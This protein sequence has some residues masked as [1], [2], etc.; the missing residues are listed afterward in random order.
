MSFWGKIKTAD[1]AIASIA[2]KISGARNFP[3]LLLPGKQ[4]GNNNIEAVQL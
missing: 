2:K 1:C 4:P 3:C